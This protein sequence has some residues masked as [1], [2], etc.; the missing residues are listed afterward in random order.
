MEDETERVQQLLANKIACLGYL[1]IRFLKAPNN[2]FD[3]S[4]A[5]SVV[6]VKDV[7]IDSL[8]VL[9][10]YPLQR[11][12]F[13]R[14]ERLTLQKVESPWIIR[15]EKTIDPTSDCPY[16]FNVF[17][18]FKQ[19][20]DLMDYLM[21]HE[22]EE[23]SEAFFQ[24]A[25][26]NLLDAVRSLHDNDFYHGDIKPENIL[27]VKGDTPCAKQFVLIDF[28]FSHPVCDNYRA[29]TSGTLWY[30]SPEILDQIKSNDHRPSDIWSLALV[31]F[32]LQTK[33]VPLQNNSIQSGSRFIN[34]FVD[35]ILPERISNPVLLDLLSKMLEQDAQLRYKI[36]DI[37]KHPYVQELIRK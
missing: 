14:A 10:V 34:E 29:K 36:D 15:L 22:N 23:I 5:N 11:E 1:V 27:V 7:S 20:M 31:L 32:V 2:F 24:Q 13:V 12:K 9:K 18:F 28:E 26:F 8:K 37:Y 25:F 16:Y 4:Q 3:L 33:S 17:P 30:A 6:L 19:S 21:E 35:S